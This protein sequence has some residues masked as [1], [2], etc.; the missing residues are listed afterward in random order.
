MKVRS[1][2]AIRTFALLLIGTM[3]AT[4]QSHA[5]SLVGPAHVV[6]GDT[7]RVNGVPVRLHGID[8]PES[9]Q[10]CTTPSSGAWACG[11]A[12]TAHLASLVK[13]QD[14]ECVSNET[15]RYGR[16]IA[17]CSADGVE[18]NSAMVRSGMAW[19]F[20]RYSKDYEALET[21]AQNARRGAWRDGA[22][23]IAPWDWR[24]GLRVASV[25]PRDG[26]AIKGN[27]QRDGDRVY[28]TQ[29]SPWYKR[30]RIN[31]AKGERW[32]CTEAEARAAGWRAAR[33]S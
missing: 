19:A 25:E 3:A 6:D 31:T 18:L 23:P 28:H 17:V 15:D 7:I 27:V 21:E 22:R 20:L 32:F 33:H 4:V 24:A 13:N 9:S 26:C 11:S 29:S 16:L 1:S 12:A 10:N 5:G 30:T 14:V 2:F 8:A